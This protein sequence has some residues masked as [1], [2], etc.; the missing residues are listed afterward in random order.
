MTAQL[1]T[2]IRLR[3]YE[4]DHGQLQLAG[5]LQQEQALLQRLAETDGQSDR[6][7][8]QL[9][10]L[11]RAGL[12]NINAIRLR[13]QYLQQLTEQREMLRSEVAIA[14]AATDEC[15]K[16]LIAADQRLQVAEKLRERAL[17]AA[18]LQSEQQAARDCEDAWRT[19][20]RSR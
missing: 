20:S 5:L 15:R 16:R 18:Q 3:Q 12:L 2:L 7:R 9:A 17:A 13:R 11:T 4:V 19:A 14:Q 8:S 1:T 10:E 6:H